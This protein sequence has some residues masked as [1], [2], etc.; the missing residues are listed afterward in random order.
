MSE[1]RPQ[2]ITSGE[3]VIR[4]NTVRQLLIQG[5]SRQ[6]I[7]QY[8][9]DSFN[10]NE[11]AVNRYLTDAKELIKQDFKDNFDKEYFKANLLERLE[12][13]YKQNYDIDDFRQCQSVIKDITAMFGL[14]EPILIDST[15]TNKEYKPI[16]FVKTKND[17]DK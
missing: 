3:R 2:D 14:A 12:D 11:D 4:V 6:Q 7:I 16:E 8:C 17:K 9:K 15:V 13:L 10:T 1:K 5:A